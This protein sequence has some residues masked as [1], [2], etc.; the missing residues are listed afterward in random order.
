MRP[1]I[2]NTN[3]LYHHGIK[4][5][6]WGVRRFQ[7]EDGSL[8]STGKKRYDTDVNKAIEKRNA[9]KKDMR[10]AAIQYNRKYSKINADKLNK[11]REKFR[12]AKQ[13]VD[14]E[15]I[16]EKLNKETNK[17]K[18]RLKLE[19]EYIKKG[20]TEEEAAVA[21]YKRTR[22]EKAVAAVAAVAITAA[23]AYVAY[24]HYDKNV[25]KVINSGDILQRIST[26]NTGAIRD[27]FYFSMNNRDNTTYRGMYGADLKGRG[28]NVFETKLRVN[29]SIKVASER[30]AIKNLRELVS[31]DKNYSSA[32]QNHLEKVHS[33]VGANP[34]AVKQT[35]AVRKGIES[36]KKGKIDANVYRALNFALPMH[37]LQTSTSV[38]KGF[39]DKLTSKGYNAI[40][41]INDKYLSG[42]NTKNPMIAFNVANSIKADSVRSLSGNEIVENFNK[43]RDRLQLEQTGADIAKKAAVAAVAAGAMKQYNSYSDKKKHTKV[44]E[45]YKK[46]YPNTKLSDAEILNKYYNY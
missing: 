31:E 29:N 39:Y 46:E 35:E 13:Q 14:N 41:D 26:N 3:Y 32:L 38:N 5:Q 17:S 36:L 21:A 44:I 12:Y 24:K 40:V 23:A 22:T 6:R 30:S 2:I 7:N 1:A 20:M 9:A 37:G 43:V 28:A 27:A 18:R 10:E 42:Y 4:G 15:K 11:A 34:R 8:T 16:K 33:V 19:Q 25:D 45:E